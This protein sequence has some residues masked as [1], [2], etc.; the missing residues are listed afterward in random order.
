M[1]V[2]IYY[3]GKS[4]IETIEFCC[5]KE[6]PTC[7]TSPFLAKL[8]KT[9]KKTPHVRFHWCLPSKGSRLSVGIYTSICRH[10]FI[11]FPGTWV[12]DVSPK[13]VV[14]LFQIYMSINIVVLNKMK[15]LFICVLLCHVQLVRISNRRWS[16]YP[17]CHFFF[18]FQT[19]VCMLRL[20]PSVILTKYN[21]T[22][23]NFWWL[24]LGLIIP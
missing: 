1:Y 21:L 10:I 18:T 13:P 19:K 16:D 22:M 24:A 23:L 3:Q 4:A 20:Y 17:R 6:R 8:K 5:H 11:L 12:E 9:T 15:W 14:D 2:F 7:L